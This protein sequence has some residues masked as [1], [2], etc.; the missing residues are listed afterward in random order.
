V[1]KINT[2]LDKMK[3]KGIGLPEHGSGRSGQVLAKDLYR[4]IGDYNYPKMYTKPDDVIHL[5]M[6]RLV[7]PMKAYRFNKLSDTI[8]DE[9]F[10][11][12]NGWL[13]EQKFNGWRVLITYVPESGFRVWGGNLSDVTCLPVDYT[14]HVRL[15]KVYKTA[16]VESVKLHPKDSDCKYL[17]PRPFILDTEALCYD[18]V[19]MLDGYTST[20]TLDSIKAI[21][22]SDKQRA[23]HLQEVENH[24]VTFH[25]FDL[26]E[27]NRGYSTF[28]NGIKDAPLSK[29]KAD[30][31]SKIAELLD[32]GFVNLHYVSCFKAGKKKF[33]KDVWSSGEEGAVLK[34]EDGFYVPG[35]RKKELCI[36]VKRT[37]SGEIG[38]D[39]DAF[40]IDYEDTEEWCKKG[41]IGSIKLGVYTDDTRSEVRHI[42]T[43]SAMPEA[44]REYISNGQ[45]QCLGK[46][47]TIDGQELSGRN[48]LIMHAV[49]DWKRGFREEKSK[50]DCVYDFGFIDE[51]K[52]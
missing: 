17:F 24:V 13:E 27:F 30:L 34:H 3:S 41:L 42:A 50:L 4:A 38:D 25:V 14:D 47:L 28:Y 19:E 15:L 45:T 21:L 49:V 35:S 44:T 40:I 52:F 48:K 29:R 8:K 22:G 39:L 33:L 36:K 37:M 5:H 46:V 11:D 31:K 9:I 2:L 16:G 10:E 18:T 51:E 32:Y 20:N 43:V 26:I 23:V 6:R 12:H 1:L 7:E